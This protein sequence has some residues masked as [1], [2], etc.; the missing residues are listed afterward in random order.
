MGIVSLAEEMEQASTYQRL[1][2]QVTNDRREIAQ[3]LKTLSDQL[4]K[5]RKRTL[6]VDRFGSKLQISSDVLILGGL[7]LSSADRPGLSLGLTVAGTSSGVLG[8]VLT[9]GASLK[10]FFTTQYS[11]Q[12]IIA[13]LEEHYRQL[14]QLFELGADQKFVEDTVRFRAT[15]DQLIALSRNGFVNM[16]L[17]LNSDQQA[18]AQGVQKLPTAL[19]PR[20]IA[21]LAKC[22]ARSIRYYRT[23]RKVLWALLAYRIAGAEVAASLPDTPLTMTAREKKKA[24]LAVGAVLLFDIMHFVSIRRQSDRDP[25]A[26]K[27]LRS[28]AQNAEQIQ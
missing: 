19:D 28:M 7:A 2:R 22:L 4:S 13:R 6:A 8:A 5:S 24:L 11:L 9:G 15:L 10:G 3:Q 27:L 12:R 18:L 25:P 21:A 16:I 20:P 1:A 14:I 23:F 17:R 26:I